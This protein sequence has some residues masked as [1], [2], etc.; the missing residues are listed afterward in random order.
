MGADILPVGTST[1]TSTS[2]KNFITAVGDGATTGNGLFMKHLF[3]TTW[4]F[5]FRAHNLGEGRD[6]SQM[7]GD[8]QESERDLYFH[9]GD[10]TA[11]NIHGREYQFLGNSEGGN[12]TSIRGASHYEQL[13]GHSIGF[14][15][16]DVTGLDELGVNVDSGDLSTDFLPSGWDFTHNF[17]HS[18]EEGNNAIV[19]FHTFKPGSWCM[20][21]TVDFDPDFTGGCYLT[22]PDKSGS[23]LSGG[24]STI[25]VKG[26]DASHNVLATDT[27]TVSVG[28][29]QVSTNW[30]AV[31]APSH[32]GLPRLPR[33]SGT[34]SN[35]AY[36]SFKLSWS[37]VSGAASY[38]I[39]IFNYSV[40]GSLLGV[41]QTKQTSSTSITINGLQAGGFYFWTLRAV[42]VPG[43]SFD[44]YRDQELLRTSEYSYD[45]DDD[46]DD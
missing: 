41:K 27:T 17:G 18:W 4:F 23:T 22:V 19:W 13:S 24:E 33:P 42:G 3:G 12:E 38:R 16:E 31:P 40:G 37:A 46:D 21:L 25:T 32:L 20:K 26:M 45:D 28:A 34:H 7:V 39:V 29:A 35:V 6:Y 1:G 36:T 15:P 8:S 44:S 5:I 9:P 2:Y 43:Q 11:F 14:P 30:G 10:G